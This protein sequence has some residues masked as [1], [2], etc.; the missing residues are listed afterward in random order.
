METFETTLDDINQLI[1][2]KH[3]V[4][5][6]VNNSERATYDQVMLKRC[7]Y[8]LAKKYT[9]SSDSD[10]ARYLLLSPATIN[11]YK[12]TVDTISFSPYYSQVYLDLS[13]DLRKANGRVTPITAIYT[14]LIDLESAMYAEIT[15]LKHELIKLHAAYKDLS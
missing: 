3:N 8:Q 2:S 15:I 9:K 13:A 1:F 6:K 11:H 7:F 12:K 5:L 4:N 10:I 14:R